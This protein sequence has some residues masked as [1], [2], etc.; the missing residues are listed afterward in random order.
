M[1]TRIASFKVPRIYEFRQE[2]PKS[3]IGKV[4]RRELKEKETEEGS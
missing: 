3:A 4:L 2:L 1:R